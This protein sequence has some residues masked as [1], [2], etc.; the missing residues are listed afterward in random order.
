MDIITKI[1]SKIFTNSQI[2]EKYK[3]W[4]SQKQKIVFT[5]GCFDVLHYGH[6]YYLAKAKSFG[7]KLIVAINSDKSV[8]KLKGESRPINSEEYRAYAIASLEAVDAVVVFNELTPAEIISKIIPDILVK[9]GDYNIQNIVGAD[10]VIKSGG[11]VEIVKFVEGC[12]SS[13][14]IKKI[15]F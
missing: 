9:G 6:F 3:F 12:S 11:K 15:G 14:I 2:I 13:K 10:Q 4:K 5:N 8:K 7:D 1:K